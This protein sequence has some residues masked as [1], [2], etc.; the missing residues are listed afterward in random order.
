[1]ARA[2]SELFQSWITF[3][4]WSTHAIIISQMST[5]LPVLKCIL[6]FLAVVSIPSMFIF[7]K[8]FHTSYGTGL[9][10]IWPNV[11]ICSRML[12]I[13][14]CTVTCLENKML[15]CSVGWKKCYFPT[16]RPA[17]E[18]KL[19]VQAWQKVF[20]LL[21]LFLLFTTITKDSRYIP[22]NNV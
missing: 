2:G 15:L 4:A 5:H 6:T 7:T 13:L 1:V 19:S 16:L 8:L 11:S 9:Y 17:S 3:P 14:I 21:L 10:E 22:M 12:V 18:I 20:L